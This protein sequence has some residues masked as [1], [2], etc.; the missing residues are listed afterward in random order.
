MLKT[1]VKINYAIEGSLEQLIRL[2]PSSGEGI[3]EEENFKLTLERSRLSSSARSLS[4]G[5]LPC[6]YGAL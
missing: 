2:Q 6:Q 1:I 5:R 3:G 4:A